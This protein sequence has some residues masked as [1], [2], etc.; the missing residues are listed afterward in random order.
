MP[1]EFDLRI[2]NEE[3]I[4]ESGILRTYFDRPV[5]TL[6]A[7]IPLTASINNKIINS[8]SPY[9]SPPAQVFLEGELFFTGQITDPAPLKTPTSLSWN[10]DGRSN[11]WPFFKS[12]LEPPYEHNGLTLEQLA[13]TVA[14]QTN[15]TIKFED[16]Q[17]PP[18]AGP[19]PNP[20]DNA[21]NILVRETIRQGQTGFTFCGP[22][23]KKQ[24]KVIS[25]TPE[26]YII[27]HQPDLRSPVIGTIE[28]GEDFRV[29]RDFKQNNGNISTVLDE[30][31]ANFD[32]TKRVRTVKAITDTRV[33]PESAISTDSNIKQPIHKIVTVTNQIP[34]G[35]Q[36]NADWELNLLAMAA[37]TKEFNLIGWRLNGNLIKVGQRITVVSPTMGFPDGFTFFINA[38]EYNK[39]STSK[40]VKISVVPPN[41]YTN[42]PVDEPWFG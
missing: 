38:C 10:A 15:T 17:T 19:P 5:H 23:A 12:M 3:V 1:Q 41:C 29:S 13:R 39:R 20:F 33:G 2:N 14:E 7:N 4:I 11:T 9:A 30:Y 26:G 8:M 35:V 25:C 16:E 32:V 18:P 42:Q 36:A 21:R 22:I 34:G 28:E 40:G 27:F 24:Q 37:L 31:Q 6:K